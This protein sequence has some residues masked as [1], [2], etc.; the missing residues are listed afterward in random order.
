MTFNDDKAKGFLLLIMAIA[1]LVV[2]V[3][4]IINPDLSDNT[5]LIHIIGLI[6]GALLTAYNFFFGSSKSSQDKDKKNK[7]QEH[8][9]PDN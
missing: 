8:E 3:A 9:K 5:L 6:E 2:V 7:I 1:F 4:V